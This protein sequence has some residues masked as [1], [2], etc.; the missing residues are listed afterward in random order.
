M[1]I[2]IN[3]MSN[4]HEL[5]LRALTASVD[6]EGTDLHE[7]VRFLP[8]EQAAVILERETGVKFRDHGFNPKPH[9]VPIIDPE[10]D[11]SS[12]TLMFESTVQPLCMVRFNDKSYNE[13]ED[14]AQDLCRSGLWD[15]VATKWSP[16]RKGK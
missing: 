12:I 5:V 9:L 13:A 4:G 15:L 14:L 10:A 2:A 8:V 3:G 11:G 6:V 16:N 1:M 7:Q